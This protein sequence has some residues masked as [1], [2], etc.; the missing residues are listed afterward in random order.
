MAAMQRHANNADVQQ[1]ACAALNSLSY[2]DTNA[3]R[4]AD[5]GAVQA[6]TAA[7]KR[8]GCPDADAALEDIKRHTGILGGIRRLFG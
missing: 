4:A 2:N 7:A 5:A 3:R 8:Y 1:Y 6:L